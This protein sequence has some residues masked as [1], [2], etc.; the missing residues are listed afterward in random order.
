MRIEQ[1]LMTSPPLLLCF[2]L[3][4]LH[5]FY[6]S[7]ITRMVGVNAHL[8]QTLRSCRDMAQRVFF[9]QIKARGDKVLRNPPPPPKDLTP[10]PQVA[11]TVHQ[12]LEIINAH[13]SALEA[14]AQPTAAQ[15]QAA[16]ELGPVL[17][18]VLDPLVDM[19]ERSSEALTPDAPSRVDDGT[20]LDP[21]AHRVYLI[22]C[23]T[24]MTSLLSHRP[25]A[26]MRVRQLGDVVEGHVAALVG[27]EVGRLLA[28]CGLS[29]VVDRLRLYL[30]AS[31]RG[32]SAGV[33]ASDP[34]LA[35]PKVVEAMRS[36]FVL[37]SSPDALPEF[38]TIQVIQ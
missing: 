3:S 28:S 22:N 9:E 32:E 36:F 23:I 1:V 6:Y 15:A 26:G 19:C 21:S 4:Q 27:G 10:P 31:S 17:S 5:A 7:L 11:E 16:D 20:K 8:S 34:G 35:L 18:A 38:R 29:E 33:P 24:A 13:E 2:Q 14:A 12:L 25:S 30:E 37:V